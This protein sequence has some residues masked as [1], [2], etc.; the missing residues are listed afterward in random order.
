M[1]ET[2]DLIQLNNNLLT[3]ALSLPPIVTGADVSN[4]RKLVSDMPA[5]EHKIINVFA[6]IIM[7]PRMRALQKKGRFEHFPPFKKFLHIIE[8]ALISYYR[9]NFIGSYLILIPVIE[10]IMLS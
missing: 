1:E 2:D 4:V 7:N 8:S 6:S 5:N 9:Y 10:E 3:Y